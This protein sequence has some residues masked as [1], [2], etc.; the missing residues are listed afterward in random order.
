MLDGGPGDNLQLYLEGEFTYGQVGSEQTFGKDENAPADYAPLLGSMGQT[1]RGV[2]VS[3]N[4]DLRVEF[5]Y[6]SEIR[7]AP[8]PQYEAW[9]LSLGRLMVISVPGGGEPAIFDP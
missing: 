2:H 8:D 3:G 6:G 1:V 5:G 9:N 4:G 7:A